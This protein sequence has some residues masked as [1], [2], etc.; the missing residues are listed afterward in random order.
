MNEK[1]ESIKN[2]I[3]SGVEDLQSSKA[4]YELK[5]HFLDSKSGKIG[6]LMKEMKNIAPEERAGFGKGVNDLKEWALQRF[7]ELDEKI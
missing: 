5:K 4:V 7:A 6:L 2:E 1:F 3:L